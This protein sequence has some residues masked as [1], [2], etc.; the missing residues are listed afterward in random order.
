MSATGSDA[1][2]DTPRIEVTIAAPI[3][4]VWQALRDPELIRRWHGWHADELDEEIRMIFVDG[5]VEDAGA[6][7]LI[8]G[9]GDRWSLLPTPGGVLV[10]IIRAPLGANPDWDAYY[11]DITEGWT[12]FLSQLRF[13]L[14]RH[15]LAPRQ[16]LMFDGPI[17]D[18]GSSLLDALGLASVA[19]LPVGTRYRTAL[20]PGDLFTGEVFA[21]AP[22]QLMLTVDGLGDGLVV[23]AQQLA[24]AHRPAGGVLIVLTAY[25][26]AADFAEVEQRWTK[27]WESARL[28]G[29]ERSWPGQEP[30]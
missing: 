2:A 4:D 15:G 16:T 19:E 26:D 10:R 9:G 17:A 6:H 25:V 27:W 14:E 7:T 22:H 24:A 21:R 29:E 28:P 23:L 13:G 12:T 11:D 3:E 1:T 20:T 18:P 30:S 8:A 5:V